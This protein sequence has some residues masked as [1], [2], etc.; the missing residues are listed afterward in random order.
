MRLC[1]IA[2]AL[3]EILS[4][5]RCWNNRMLIVLM[6]FSVQ[7][8]NISHGAL[9]SVSWESISVDTKWCEE[10]WP[11]IGQTIQLPWEEGLHSSYLRNAA[12]CLGVTAERCW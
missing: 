4:D 9:D 6:V 2:E 7:P 3:L 8:L 10:G 11:V 5:T 12:W 1:D